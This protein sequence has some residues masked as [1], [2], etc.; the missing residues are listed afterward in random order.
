MRFFLVFALIIVV[1]MMITTCVVKKTKKLPSISIL[2]LV[3]FSPGADYDEMYK[4][5]SRFYDT[6]K[7]VDTIYYV[8]D[9]S[10]Q[11]SYTYDKSSKILRIR[12]HETYVPGIL[13]KTVLA[14]QYVSQLGKHYDYIVR[15]NISTV[16]NFHVLTKILSEQPAELAGGRLSYLSKEWRDVPAGIDNDRYQGLHYLTGTC[17]VM[18]NAFFSKVMSVISKIDYSVIDD[19]ALGQLVRI[20]LPSTKIT[21]WQHL[22]FPSSKLLDESKLSEVCDRFA[23]FRN[24]LENRKQDVINIKNIS[25]YLTKKYEHLR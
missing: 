13:H 17:I 9:P 4:Y 8:F 14:F 20:Y 3:L 16:V 18:S 25:S 7:N 15:T 19:V 6:C 24:K 10:I 1:C 22:Y 2:N 23:I 21:H 11:S 12:G 5:T